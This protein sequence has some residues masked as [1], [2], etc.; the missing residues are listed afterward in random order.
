MSG[1]PVAESGD[2][3]D[4]QRVEWEAHVAKAHAAGQCPFSGLTT[5]ACIAS[6]CDCFIEQYPDD[7]YGLHPEAF[8]V[9]PPAPTT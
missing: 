7:P 3:S 5:K 6:I 8:V 1:P 9:N 2:E 4:Q